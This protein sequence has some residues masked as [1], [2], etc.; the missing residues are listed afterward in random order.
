M[1]IFDLEEQPKV[2]VG[3]KSWSSLPTAGVD[4]YGE[5]EGRKKRR[6]SWPWW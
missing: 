3:L 2:I 1:G 6:S 4:L 5:K